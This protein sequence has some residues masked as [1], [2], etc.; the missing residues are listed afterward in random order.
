MSYVRS[1]EMN[2][3]P[4]LITPR[5]RGAYAYAVRKNSWRPVGIR[6]SGRYGSGW[7]EELT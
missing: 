6:M 5:L 7:D 3:M 1:T 2:M 4:Q